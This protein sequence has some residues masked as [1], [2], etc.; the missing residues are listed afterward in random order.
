MRC[1]ACKT[2]SLQRETYEGFNVDKC[3]ECLGHLIP[4]LR[5]QGISRQSKLSP[6][7][8]EHQVLLERG[9][10]SQKL[11]GCPRCGDRMRKLNKARPTPFKIDHCIKCDV[12]W[13][14]GGELALMQLS[15]ESSAQAEESREMRRRWE[16]MSDERRAQFRENLRKLPKES[17][18]GGGLWSELFDA[19]AD[20]W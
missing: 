2:I 17:P 10:D 12:L 8:L 1:P 7:D 9:E 16:E 11:L 4:R 3:P 18:Q 19:F 13:L 20:D 14:D 5:Q 6:E 15:Y